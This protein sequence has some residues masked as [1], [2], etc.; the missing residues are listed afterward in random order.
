MATLSGHAPGTFC[1]PE[2]YTTDQNG[3]KAFYCGLFG[4]GGKDLPMGPDRAYT[5]FTLGDRDAAA[6]YG[7]TP[8]ME[9]QGIPPHWMAY[10]AVGSADQTTAKAKAS[11]GSALKEPFDVMGIGRMAVLRDP[12]GAAFCVWES[13]GHI[14]VGVLNEPNAL[15]WTELMTGDPG[16]AA[17]FYQGVFGWAA[18][19]WPMADGSTYH[20]FMR[21]E[22]PAGG[23]IKITPQMGPVPPVWV[24]YFQ[25]QDCDAAAAAASRL[26]G[27][28]SI[29]TQ[30]VPDV[31]KFAILVDP[32][33]AHFG[34]MQP[35][36][37]G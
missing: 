7:S 22:S 19:V 23:M 32:A 5:I 25:V 14:G 4:W 20:V 9:Q 10:V 30:D 31:G 1:W 28:I 16:K 37:R 35:V 27:R 12:T 6:C 8:E 17:A 13:K 18:R 21:G 24:S 3:A 29:P 11:G 33:G 26:G 2:L 15:L 34:I 36:P